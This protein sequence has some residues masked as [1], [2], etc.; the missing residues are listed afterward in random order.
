M[1]VQLL[2][3]ESEANTKTALNSLSTLLTHPENHHLVRDIDAQLIP[4]LLKFIRN[5][6]P[7]TYYPKINAMR[8][9]RELSQYKAFV[10]VMIEHQLHIDFFQALAALKSSSFDDYYASALLSLLRMAEY[11][12]FIE[13]LRSHGSMM[14]N[15]GMIMKSTD[16]YGIQATLLFALL[17]GSEERSTEDPNRISL[18]LFQT[19]LTT[20]K[21][22]IVKKSSMRHPPSTFKLSTLIKACCEIIAS[23]TSRT[24]FA[25]CHSQLRDQLLQVI[26]QT[27]S[28][29]PGVNP[30][31]HDDSIQSADY[32]VKALLVLSF[33]TE[34]DRL[35]SVG[36]DALFPPESKTY[37]IVTSYHHFRRTL[38][39]SPCMDPL[40][41]LYRLDANHE[42]NLETEYKHIFLSYAQGSKQIVNELRKTLLQMGYAVWTDHVIHLFIS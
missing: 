4:A 13:D 28:L 29:P 11:S 15:F 23:S 41:L 37:E 18:P 9:I 5:D 2:I 30:P 36:S 26:Q 42:T 22:T 32:A 31:E 40:L 6:K 21:N 20:L 17:Y 39:L 16:V 12:E 24:E 35:L 25:T 34:E 1:L 33:V 8:V 3:K 10:T 7:P 27:S 14:N 38:P 19:I